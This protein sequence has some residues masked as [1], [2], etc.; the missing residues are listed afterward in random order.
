MSSAPREACSPRCAGSTT[1]STVEEQ[2]PCDTWAYPIG[3][4]SSLATT[5]ANPVAAAGG[6][7]EPVLVRHRLA[8]V[9]RLGVGEQPVDGGDPVAVEAAQDLDGCARFD[10][11]ARQ[12]RGPP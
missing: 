9:R 7:V 10:R 2:F 12:S 1:S 11:S 5:A 4:P 8:A 3:R 6:E